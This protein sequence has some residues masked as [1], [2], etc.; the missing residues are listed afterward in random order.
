MG[1]GLRNLLLML[2][3]VAAF[4][5]LGTWQLNRSGERQA[6]LQAFEQA[7][8]AAPA[9]GLA[10]V[11]APGD[12]LRV[13]LSGRYAGG[14]QILMDNMT[15]EGARGYHVLT[16]LY[17]NS[18]VVLINRGFVPAGM[19]RS[20]L[21]DLSVDGGERQ[22]IGLAAPYF[23]AGLELQ[24]ESRDASWPRRMTYPTSEQLRALIDTRLP[25]YQIL[26][27]SGAADGYVRAWQPYGMLPERHLAYAV[28]W[29]GLAAAAVGIWLAIAIKRRRA[30][31]EN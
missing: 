20:Q 11:S 26:L 22:V 4:G 13:K 19:D 9:E 15:H 7:Q 1:A 27:D 25:E 2:L 24:A 10:E 21:P 23:R 17:M 3:G 16:P 31:N 28:Q 5:W 18:G 8:A 12:Y 6:E 30:G 29:Y 14:R